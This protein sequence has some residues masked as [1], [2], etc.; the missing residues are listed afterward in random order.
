VSD[1]G[2]NYTPRLLSSHLLSFSVSLFFL[3]FLLCLLGLYLLSVTYYFPLCFPR[4]LF[5]I[6][7]FEIAWMF[8]FY[9]ASS[10]FVFP[11]ANP[12]MYYPRQWVRPRIDDG[13][14]HCSKQNWA[15]H[16]HI[17]VAPYVRLETHPASLQP[18]HH[19]SPPLLTTT[20]Q[21]FFFCRIVF[22]NAKSASALKSYVYPVFCLLYPVALLAHNSM[23][24]SDTIF[25][26]LSALLVFKNHFNRFIDSTFPHVFGTLCFV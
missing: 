20:C 4:P 14:S 10:C 24:S 11:S 9:A 25:T 3:S 18:D 6:P 5:A 21:A 15:S 19:W 12:C 26:W 13:R 1:A 8:P 16:N 17:I 2:S 22:G 7:V 23:V